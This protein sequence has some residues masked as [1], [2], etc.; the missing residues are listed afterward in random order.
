MLMGKI[1]KRTINVFAVI[2]LM[3]FASQNIF[4]DIFY[5]G[6]FGSPTGNYFTSI[7]LA[8]N[9]AADG[10]SVIVSNGTY[11]LNSQIDVDKSLTIQSVNG[12]ENTIVNGN[13]L[14]RCFNLYNHNTVILGFTITNGKV[15][16]IGD[17]GGGVYC[18]G[19]TPGIKNCIIVK[20]SARGYGGGI[21]NG[22]LKNCIII[23]NSAYYGGGTSG[24]II[25]NCVISKNSAYYGGGTYNSII[26]N[27]T[28]TLNSAVGNGGG[29]I[30]CDAR[31]SI[32]YYNTSPGLPNRAY[33]TYSYCCTTL[34]GISGTGN[35]SAEPILLSTSHIATN[36]P[37]IRA[38]LWSYTSGKDIDGENWK[39]PP[40][41]GCDEVYAN[42]ISG[43]LSVTIFVDRTNTYA[44]ELLTFSSY[45]N[46]KL[47]HS[48][49]NFDD[50]TVETNKSLVAHS[51]NSLGEHCVT[52]TA[53]NDTYS[54]GVSD[55]ITIQVITNCH[56]VNINNTTPVYPYLSWDTAATNIQDAV[57]AA[58]YDGN[59]FVANGYY[60]LDSAIYVNE[61]LKIRSVNGPE[62]TIIDGKG[63][64]RC[65]YI[66]THNAVIS[67]FTITNGW[68]A[69]DY[70]V[71][72]GY[73][74]GINCVGE[75][76]I[77]NCVICGNHAIGGGGLYQ[78]IAKNCIIS[79]NTAKYGGGIYA[80]VVNNSTIIENSAERGGGANN[81]TL[82]NSMIFDNYADN[83][84]GGAL[85][86]ILNNCVV[87]NNYA[88]YGGGTD[89]G[90]INNSIV[91]YNFASQN[92]NRHYGTYNYCCT[93]PDGTNGTGNISAEPMLVNVSH[94]S[95]N[96]PCVGAGFS[97][98]VSGVDIDGEAWKNPPSIGCDEVY[99]NAI[100][101]SL[102]V[103]IGAE[104]KYIY[105][106]QPLFL[107]ADIEGRLHQNIWTFDDGTAETNKVQVAHSWNSPG[108]YN[109]ILT[110]FNDTY[111]NGISA[112][113]VIKVVTNINYV[114]INNP[115][116]VEPYASWET[117]ATNIQNAVDV[118]IDG[119]KIL[120]TNGLYI[121]NSQ[122]SINKS[123]SI[124]SI[125]GPEDTVINGNNT[126]R[127][128]YLYNHNTAISGFKITKGNAVGNNGG[129]FYCSGTNPVISN[130]VIIDNSAD[131]TA[132]GVYKGTIY[133]CEIIGNSAENAGGT[134]NSI[135]NNSAVFRNSA[136]SNGGGTYN[137]IVNNCT[138][139]WNA[140]ANDGGGTYNSIINNSIVYYNSAQNYSNRYGGTY[141]YCCTTFDGISGTGNIGGPPQFVDT[142]LFNYKLKSTSPCI[143]AGNNSYAPMPVDLD[144]NPRI[145]DGIV[146]M[147]CYES[148]YSIPKIA[149]DALTFPAA[150]S[151]LYEGDLTNVIWDIEKITDSVDGTNL[152]IT[153][154]SLHLAETTNNVSEVTN[155]VDNLLGEIP[156][157]V[158]VE[159]V[160]GDTDYVL[161]FEA[162]NSSSIT[163]IR[164]FWDNEF[165]IVPEPMLLTLFASLIVI[166]L[167]RY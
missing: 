2:I 58:F 48:I 64:N 127:C 138:I 36:S 107:L 57:N 3:F 144:G 125:N 41:I 92:P 18:S 78:G 150:G 164:I 160:G 149:T 55:S 124:Q 157:F 6:Q 105:I 83:G 7:Q 133:N 67:G 59:I 134:Y 96:S 85:N 163:N 120:V 50:G 162:V 89:S 72:G 113:L 91:Y 137:G 17:Y 99:A 103:A 5:V 109:V 12:A 68:A 54:N 28:I 86:S 20:N 132:G 65:F 61:Y 100:T 8:V 46:G 166:W 151:E 155:N 88:N 98:Y 135:V 14:V 79:G 66:N 130:C 108:E 136:N 122:I 56:F 131:N 114:N 34:D 90:T 84:G 27:C 10:D 60:L 80:S 47:T 35:I 102:S 45:I 116:P 123:V 97:N 156:W 71:S 112:S 126:N 4:A 106:G 115:T 110:A 119:G 146:D 32:I 74:G 30:H 63:S 167:R 143:N 38:G 145:F 75:S 52:L 19:T 13:N 104:K 111:S 31:N 33:G 39:N 9:V 161:E 158:P 140:V 43:S 101:G 82:N 93:P 49:W 148:P 23:E 42:A 141:N 139:I 118:A 25:S 154:I 129:G 94:I 22:T 117:A 77:I 44:G 159:F 53:Y 165:T 70:N 29:T 81:C 1:T 87:I 147:G 121:L 69:N 152:V 142:N 16:N 21:Y 153:K 73:G 95:T 37:C 15:K 76:W 62:N 24:G 128:F 11:I 51:W 26:N 40:S